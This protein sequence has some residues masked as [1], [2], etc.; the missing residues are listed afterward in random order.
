L[1]AAHRWPDCVLRLELARRHTRLDRQ[2]RLLTYR[3]Q[4]FTK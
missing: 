3:T 2:D 1:T 4:G